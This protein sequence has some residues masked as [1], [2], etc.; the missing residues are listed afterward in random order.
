MANLAVR[1]AVFQAA[2][3]EITELADHIDRLQW[4]T[5]QSEGE[6]DR[7]VVCISLEQREL[8]DLLLDAIDGLR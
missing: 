1:C 3:E 5:R 2:A 8:L 6:G 4:E 7:A